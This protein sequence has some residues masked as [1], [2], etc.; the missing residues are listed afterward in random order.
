MFLVI[1]IAPA[2][3][4][5][6]GSTV[7]ASAS[8]SG[9][10]TVT[11]STF[12]LPVSAGTTKVLTVKGVVKSAPTNGSSFSVTLPATTGLTGVDSNGT[13]RNN[14]SNTITGNTMYVYTKA[15]VF[16]YVS[17]SATVKGSNSTTNPQDIG[18]TSITFSV[19]ANGGDIYIPTKSTLATAL[20]ETLTGGSSTTTT[21]TTWTCVSPAEDSS[22]S[23]YWRIPSGQTANCSF[24][25]LVTNTGGTAGYF[26]VALG[27]VSWNTTATTTSDVDQTWGLTNIKTA[28]F[29]GF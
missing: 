18:D 9:S 25:T 21:S 16:A 10:G 11:W 17:S 2:L 19:T 14:G 28:D 23:G 27:N 4:L 8:A 5:Y 3:E 13:A 22:S 20:Q 24:S 12:T 6:D 26:S 7:L 15:P 1:P 29:C